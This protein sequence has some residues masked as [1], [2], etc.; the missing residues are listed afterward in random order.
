MRKVLS[1][2]LCSQTT[3]E[4]EAAVNKPDGNTCHA[5]ATIKHPDQSSDDKT[6]PYHLTKRRADKSVLETATRPALPPLAVQ[7]DR[8]IQTAQSVQARPLQVLGLNHFNITASPALIE[9]VKRFY[10]DVIGL[11]I[12]PRAHLDHQGYWLYA[13]EVPI[14]HLSACRSVSPVTIIQKG[15]FNHISLSCVGLTQAISKMLATA[16]P[17]RIIELSDIHQTQLFLT[18]PAGIGVELT[19]FNEYF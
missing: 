5:T 18:D 17:Y 8:P 7:V 16:T 15:Y 1:S 14:L 19:F 3:S 12:G 13:G 4:L 2:T 11:T 10:I 6:H 9:Q